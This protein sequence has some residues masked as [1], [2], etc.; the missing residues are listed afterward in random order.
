MDELLLNRNTF[1]ITGIRNHL[2]TRAIFIVALSIR[3]IAK[4]CL[5]YLMYFFNSVDDRQ[6]RYLYVY[7]LFSK[8]VIL[9]SI[10]LVTL[11]L[12]FEKKDSSIPFLLHHFQRQLLMPFK[13]QLLVSSKSIGQTSLYLRLLV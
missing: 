3:T 8:R 4:P 5:N 6:F 12:H 10:L 13:R 9:S 7:Q 1:A 2:Q 11:L